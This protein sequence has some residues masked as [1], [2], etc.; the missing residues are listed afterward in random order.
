MLWSQLF[1]QII[2]QLI[3]FSPNGVVAAPRASPNSIPSQPQVLSKKDGRFRNKYSDHPVVYPSTWGHNTEEISN[4]RP[5]HNG[6]LYYTKNG[7]NSKLFRFELS[8]LFF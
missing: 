4:L 8:V 5:N 3:L 6:Q 7:N 2:L 1:C